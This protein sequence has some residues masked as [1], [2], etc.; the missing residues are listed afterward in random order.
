MRYGIFADIHSNLEALQNVLKQLKLLGMDRYCCLGDLVGYG[1]HPNDVVEKIRSLE[2]V[3]VVAGN[4][5]YGSVDK[6]SVANFNQYAQEAIAFTKKQLKPENAA[7][8]AS[9][10]ER[11]VG[12][13]FMM[14]HGSPLDPLNEYL[15]T[16]EQY[17]A[18][19]GA[20]TKDICFIGHS[21][22]VFNMSKKETGPVEVHR[23]IEG[24]SIRVEKGVRLV[25]NVGSVG[26]PRDGDPRAACAVYDTDM[27][28]ITIYRF[29]YAIPAVQFDMKRN[30]LPHFLVERLAFGH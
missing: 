25:V 28:R 15:L 7:Y 11:F 2:N 26:Q 24:E 14:V 6:I 20:F 27:R 1:P 29:S 10:P 30:N 19:E 9:L 3:T 13:D 21:H 12:D 22:I 23:L 16:P 4:H 8:L 17:A 18:N 5:D